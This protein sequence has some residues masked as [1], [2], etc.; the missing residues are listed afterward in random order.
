MEADILVVNHHLFL[1]DIALKEEGFG[2]LLPKV[3]VVIFD[4]AHQ[5][6]DTA[7]MYFS[8]GVSQRQVLDLCRDT[9]M[10]DVAEK[11]GISGLEHRI[12]EL[13]TALDKWFAVVQEEREMHLAE[14]KDHKIET[15]IVNI[16]VNGVSQLNYSWVRGGIKRGRPSYVPRFHPGYLFHNLRWVTFDVNLK[17]I[18]SNSP[19]IHKSLIVQSIVDDYVYHTQSQRQV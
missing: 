4:E 6:P 14:F 10:A 17:C 5:V 18:K 2:Q 12:D 16:V 13:E 11:S 8:T 1:A 3:D 7:S 15:E 9:R 19:V